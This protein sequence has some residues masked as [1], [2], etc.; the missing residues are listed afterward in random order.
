MGKKLGIF[1]GVAPVP[2]N[3]SWV[4]TNGG[5]NPYGKEILAPLP[6]T[7]TVTSI[8]SPYARMHLFEVAFRQLSSNANG[9]S[10]EMRKC[11]AHCLDVYELL[12]RLRTAEKLR[13]NGLHIDLHR[14]KDVA[15]APTRGQ[16]GKFTSEYQYLDALCTFR[17]S[18]IRKYGDTSLFKVFFT[19][20]KDSDIIAATSP[21]TGFYV[22]ENPVQVQIGE[23]LYFAKDSEDDAG[24]NQWKGIEERSL[25]VQEFI[26]K[27]VRYLV[28]DIG[29]SFTQRY[30]DLWQ[31][32]DN[33]VTGDKVA[34]NGKSFAETY[35]DFDFAAFGTGS[36]GF[37]ILTENPAWNNKGVFVIPNDYEA[38]GLRY[39]L[40]PEESARFRLTSADYTPD[41]MNRVN[42]ITGLPMPWVSVDDF[43][44]DTLNIIQGE[45]NNEAY[46]CVKN[47]DDT[48]D[49]GADF[50]VLPPLKK[51]FFEFFRIEDLLKK[52]D[53]AP[54]VQ[55]SLRHRQNEDG[56]TT[57]LYTIRVPYLVTET[58]PDGTVTHN[59]KYLSLSKEYDNAH[60]R[61]GIGVELGIYP[62]LKTPDNVDDFY[63][64][65]CY[66]SN[67]MGCTDL[68]L[69]KL[70]N[71]FYQPGTEPLKHDGL[72]VKKSSG[73]NDIATALNSKILYYALNGTFFTQAKGLNPHEDV[74]FDLLNIKY[75]IE[76]PGRIISK[77]QIIVPLM[78]KVELNP[79]NI[80]IAID[81]GTS[82]T[83]VSFAQGAAAPQAFETCHS[84]IGDVHFVKLGKVEGDSVTTLT[85]DKYDMRGLY[86]L[87]QRS[88][89]IPAYF[90]DAND[91]YHFPVPSALNVKNTP[92]SM[93][94]GHENTPLSTLFDVN[95]PFAYYEDG[96]RTYNGNPIDDV[97]FNFKWFDLA[98]DEKKAQAT[99]YAEELCLMLRSNL[100]ARE[101]SLDNVELI[102]T[103]PLAFDGNQITFYNKLWKRIYAKYFNKANNAAFMANPQVNIE[104]IQEVLSD[105]ESRTPLFSDP[106][107]LTRG[108]K[109]ISADIG[110]GSTDVMVYDDS[111]IPT[112]EMCFSYKFAGNSLFCGEVLLNRDNIWYK[113]I[114]K[115]ILPQALRE[116][117]AG[118]IQKTAVADDEG[119]DV[120][121]LINKC[122]SDYRLNQEIINRLPKALGCSL[123]LTLHNCAIIYSLADICRTYQH[124]KET[125][126]PTNVFF[127]GNGSRMLFLNQAMNAIANSQ[128]MLE[129]VTKAIFGA[130]LPNEKNLFGGMNIKKSSAPKAATA[131]GILIGKAAGKPIGAGNV[132][133]CVIYGD[134]DATLYKVPLIPG[135]PNPDGSPTPRTKA[136]LQADF[137]NTENRPIY[138]SVME[139]VKEFLKI[140][141]EQVLPFFPEL[142]NEFTY[143]DS[144]EN[145]DKERINTKRNI[146]YYL[147]VTG[148]SFDNGY[149]AGLSKGNNNT[150]T[151]SLFF[152][153]ISQIIVD[154]CKAL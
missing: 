153:V 109:I 145:K 130:V 50:Q 5:V 137:A 113:E 69:H 33:K 108:A 101:R 98:D 106:A 59:V 43:L 131:N 46:F 122:F 83:Y 148:R 150:F 64:I 24:N 141:F 112:R 96:T 99:L 88:E 21:F 86:R 9:V 84:N 110:G 10:D 26:Y 79:T 85:K 32:I 51:R 76:E 120:I 48:T 29:G 138:D 105:T 40:A 47:E 146:Y 14:Y 12:Y 78:K 53:T 135:M 72:Y 74:S 124:G 35:P 121:E 89:L 36:H 16:N 81:F 39:L 143:D 129:M 71:G 37:P 133:H 114:L 151:D 128:R 92:K 87:T 27:L 66:A 142:N 111:A 17:N 68:E 75:N 6:I 4:E 77:E 54:R 52:G 41:I 45:I 3:K 91:G 60:C 70:T 20:S 65:A 93:M 144:E 149:Q 67:S 127:S 61:T 38:C 140:Y 134:K 154:L 7:T 18:Y 19:L 118:L 25:D 94:K 119:R 152:A 62:F 104:L 56:E 100:L 30:S 23:D 115:N 73:N 126:I 116:T 107:L 103:Y 44:D 13:N 1:N 31:Y 15:E 125:W 97:R 90:A 147:T 82:N 34:W 22:K 136:E 49:R 28:N 8:P 58:M 117:P 132:E 102:F 139:N 57:C 55:F 123:L 11:V 42:P 80:T 95:I 63:R 2:T